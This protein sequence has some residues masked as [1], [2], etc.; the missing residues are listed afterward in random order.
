MT[1][2]MT[3]CVFAAAFF[4]LARW[5]MRNAPRLVPASSTQQRREKD[6]R[7][8]RRGARSCFA[9]GV[10]FTLFGLLTALDVIT[11]TGTTR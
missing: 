4:A 10:L 9:V 8:L 3:S 11:G 1:A 7:S 2:A 6:E 5:G